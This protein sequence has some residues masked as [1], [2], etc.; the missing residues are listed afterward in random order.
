MFIEQNIASAC[1]ESATGPCS[2]GDSDRH[3]LSQRGRTQ[4][5]PVCAPF[6]N[7][8]NRFL[9]LSIRKGFTLHRGKE[10]LG[11]AI[12]VFYILLGALHLFFYCL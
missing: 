3:M 4:V 8:K 12:E 2:T 9:R 1:E 11:G 5:H 7:F 6:M 10:L